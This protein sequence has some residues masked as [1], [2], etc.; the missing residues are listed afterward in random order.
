MIEGW[1]W[2]DGGLRTYWC[3]SPSYIAMYIY[4]YHRDTRK[5]GFEELGT[6][7]IGRLLLTKLQ[8]WG[9]LGADTPLT[10]PR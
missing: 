7:K 6:A 10:L 8:D 3:G 5:W 9:Q 1:A 4:C 2:Y